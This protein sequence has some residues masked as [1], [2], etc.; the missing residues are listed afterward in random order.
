MDEEVGILLSAINTEMGILIAKA[1]ETPQLN[2]AHQ[3]ILDTA[4]KIHALIRK[5]VDSVGGL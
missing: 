2:P 1:S 4:K 3:E 5:Y